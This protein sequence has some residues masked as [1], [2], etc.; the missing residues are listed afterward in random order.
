MS[1][2]MSFFFYRQLSYEQSRAW[3]P[4]RPTF[5]KLFFSFLYHNIFA[6]DSV[7]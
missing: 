2:D 1:C 4:S 3:L 6:V 7:D 5:I